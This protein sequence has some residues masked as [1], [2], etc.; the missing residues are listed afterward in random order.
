M[1]VHFVGHTIG[2]V[3]GP[4]HGAEEVA[5]I[6][7]MKAH[8]FNM[9]GSSRSYWDFF[10]GFGFDASLN[11]L[12]QAVLLWLLAGVARTDTAMARPFIA[13]F[14]LAWAAGVPLCIRY[15]FAAPIVFGIV[16]VAVLVAA[17]A[18]ARRATPC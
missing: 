11:M 7:A 3:Q 1:L 10:L 15:F 16:M 14:A 4:S 9:M 18:T 13:A 8:H 5:V 17:W 12:L 6:E 2:M